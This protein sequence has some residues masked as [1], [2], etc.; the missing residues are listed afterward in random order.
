M[1]SLIEELKA[2]QKREKL[3]QEQMADRIGFSQATLSRLYAGK[4]ELGMESLQQI[5]RAY[6]E[7]SGFFLAENLSTESP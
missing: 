6:P 4:Q 2:R 7:L 3:T 5:L 1:E